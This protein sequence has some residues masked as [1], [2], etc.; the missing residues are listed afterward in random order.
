MRPIRRIIVHCAATPEGGHYT[1]ADIDRWHRARGWRS[2]GYHAVV[3]LDGTIEPGRPIEQPG[4]HAVGHNHDTLA[5]CYI[6]GV[7]ADGRTPKDTRTE[8]QRAA[9]LQQIRAWMVEHHIPVGRVLGHREL[10]PRKACPSFD[11]ATL[12][13]EL[14][15]APAV[16]GSAGPEPAPPARALDP[17]ER[18]ADRLEQ[19]MMDGGLRDL[20]GTPA[21]SAGRSLQIEIGIPSDDVDAVLGPQTRAYLSRYLAEAAQMA[22]AVVDLDSEGDMPRI[23]R[24]Y[25][26]GERD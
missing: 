4:A 6:G 24:H 14:L 9:L 2:I 12:R 7:A 11:P 15:G 16:A 26:S 10:D 17:Y 5:I 3:L 21:E 19:W 18:L 23:V 25:Y 13:A 20:R 8:R 1:A 22:S